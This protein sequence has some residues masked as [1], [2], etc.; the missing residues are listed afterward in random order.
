MNHRR[1]RCPDCKR[2]DFASLLDAATHHCPEAEA[3]K[4]TANKEMV[5]FVLAVV[6]FGAARGANWRRPGTNGARAR[7]ARSA[8]K[9][10]L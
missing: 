8:G 10:R 6:A 2:E 3:R 7:R 4:R 9:P 5:V 1:Y